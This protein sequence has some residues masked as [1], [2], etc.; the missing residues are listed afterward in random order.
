MNTGLRLGYFF[1]MA[2]ASMRRSPIVQMVAV[3]TIAMSMLV[4]G[5]FLTVLFNVDRVT[6][7]WSDETTVVAFLQDDASDAQLKALKG[8]I[9]DWKE[10]EL[11]RTTNRKEAL[12]AFQKSLGEDRRLLDGIDPS[13]LPASLELVVAPEFRKPDVLKGLGVGDDLAHSSLRLSLGR[14]TTEEEVDYAIE[15]ICTAVEKLRQLSPLYD[16]HKEGIDITKIEWQ[17]H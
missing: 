13:L 9:E 6:D 15:N 7:R 2:L 17:A 3:S 1:R 8:E 11:V 5:V 12:A 14:W 4:L 16:M 10:V